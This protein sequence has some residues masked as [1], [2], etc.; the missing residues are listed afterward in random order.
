MHNV[1]LMKHDNDLQ[2]FHHR[3][4]EHTIQPAFDAILR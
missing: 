2:L 3:L 4:N 1:T